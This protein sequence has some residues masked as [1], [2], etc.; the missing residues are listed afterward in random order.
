MFFQSFLV[1]IVVKVWFQIQPLW[2]YLCPLVSLLYF[3]WEHPRCFSLSSQKILNGETLQSQEKKTQIRTLNGEKLSSKY[4]CKTISSLSVNLFWWNENARVTFYMFSS[5]LPLENRGGVLKRNQ[6]NLN[7]RTKIIVFQ[8]KKT[9]SS[10]IFKVVHELLMISKC[11]CKSEQA[12][13]FVTL[14]VKLL[15]NLLNT[16]VKNCQYYKGNMLTHIYLNFDTHTRKEKTICLN[17]SV[18]KC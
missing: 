15:V 4:C 6:P 7:K 2:F 13:K 9:K 12:Y 5:P 10:P 17:L 14:S 18:V 8:R 11:I 3:R 1:M 16:Y